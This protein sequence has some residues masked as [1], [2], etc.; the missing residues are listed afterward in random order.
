MRGGNSGRCGFL[1]LAKS[2]DGY[3]AELAIRAADKSEKKVEQVTTRSI[4][5]K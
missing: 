5:M 3:V 2:F 1:R 4:E